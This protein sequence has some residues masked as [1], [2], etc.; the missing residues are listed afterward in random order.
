MDLR[1]YINRGG[2]IILRAG[3]TPETMAEFYAASDVI[4]VP[5]LYEP[6]GYVVREAM[7]SK[8]CVIAS[9]TG[10]IRESVTHNQTG[11][12]F[13]AGNVDQLVSQLKSVISDSEFRHKLGSNAR[14]WI[15][16]KEGPKVNVK[17]N[18]DS[19]YRQI[20]FGFSPRGAELNM[21]HSFLTV[22]DELYT[23][24]MAGKTSISVYDAAV[25]S[26]RIASNVQANGEAADSCIF[27]EEVY[28]AVAS[29]V[30]TKLRRNAVVIAFSPIV[31]YEMMADLASALLGAEQADTAPIFING[32]R[33]RERL[34]ETGLD[35]R[36]D[37]S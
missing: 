5:S 9:D 24:E 11:L 30:H 19:I 13:D 34:R 22:V 1:E 31:L 29:I 35:S 37:A 2:D 6:M 27:D 7:A 12:L 23:A 36:G 25:M 15:T 4:V 18:L 8:R 21:S 3:N 16:Q 33:T 20:A 28:K 17:R 14:S 26:C 10:G 32:K